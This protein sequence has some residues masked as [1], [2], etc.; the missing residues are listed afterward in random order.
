MA[1]GILEKMNAENIGDE[2]NIIPYYSITLDGKTVAINDLIGRDLSIE[3]LN[4]IH[5]IKCGRKTKKSFGQ[6][7]C[8]PCLISAPEAEECV[9]RPELCHAHEGIARDMEFAKEHCLIDHFVYLAWSGGL[10]VGITRYHQI[11]TRWIDQGATLAIKVCRTQNRFES[12]MVEI[13]LKKI[14]NDKTHWQAMLKGIEDN[15]IDLLSEKNNALNY[16]SGKDLRF[17]LETDDLYRINFPV[18]RYPNKVTS[19]SLDKTA[20]FSGKLIGIKGQYLIFDSNVVFNVRNHSGYLI[21]LNI[22]A[23]V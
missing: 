16:I 13:E 9:L 22:K 17:K 7:F 21:D 5:C 15:T 3:Y 14:L 8:Y 11:P 19:L 20:T 2:L 1:K 23:T 12:G 6:G 4:E 10:K 18:T